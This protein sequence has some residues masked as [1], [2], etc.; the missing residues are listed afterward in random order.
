MLKLYSVTSLR[1]EYYCMRESV[2]SDANA[3][4]TAA[5]NV[6]LQDRKINV[7]IRT[8]IQLE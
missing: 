6:S 8:T 7:Y 5:V 4:L 1:N 3:I 2:K